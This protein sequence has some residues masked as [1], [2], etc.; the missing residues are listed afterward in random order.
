MIFSNLNINKLNYFAAKEVS[1]KPLP[2]FTGPKLILG[3][4]S[5]KFSR[6]NKPY[7]REL[8][9]CVLLPLLLLVVQVRVDLIDHRIMLQENDPLSLYE[10]Q[11]L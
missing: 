7:P 9:L 5:P 11:K 3:S 8:G 6:A 2:N 4:V 1:N 10:K